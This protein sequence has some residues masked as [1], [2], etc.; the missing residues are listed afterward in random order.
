MVVLRITFDGRVHGLAPGLGAI[1]ADVFVLSDLDGL[2]KGL[3]EISKGGSGL[4][5]DVALGG[6]GK[7][8]A[9]G[10]AEVAGRE[11][12]AREEIGNVFSELLGGLGLDFFASVEMAEKRMG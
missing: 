9:Q 7:E 3:G 5:F 6:G 11:I 8:A 10:G 12:T 2:E 1:G 4:G